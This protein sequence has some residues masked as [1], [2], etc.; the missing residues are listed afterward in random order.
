MISEQSLS[1]I[2]AYIR[3]QQVLEQSAHWQ[4]ARALASA[5]LQE[6]LLDPGSLTAKFKNHHPQFDVVLLQ[7]A[8]KPCA[9]EEA[10]FLA[11]PPNAPTIVREVLLF[12][13]Q[14]PVVYARSVLPL[15]AL[16]END[17]ALA[18]L[19]T[20]PLGEHLFTMGGV[21]P[22]AIQIT[23]CVEGS[24]ISTLDSIIC[25]ASLTSP[26]QSPLW[27]RR[28]QFQLESGAILVAEVFL[29]AAPCYA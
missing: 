13:N 24:P 14:S 17:R 25:E 29:S 27:A 9:E 21:K 18:E 4:A 16:S 5:T 12:S 23:Q 10:R 19:G 2:Q 1:L 22:G 28:R 26:L 20:N 6:W 3:E 11:L 15:N 7:Q 8:Q